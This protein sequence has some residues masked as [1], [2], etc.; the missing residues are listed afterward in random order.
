MSPSRRY[1]N[2]TVGIGRTGHMFGRPADSL[3]RALGNPW[4][5]IFATLCKITIKDDQSDPIL[6][7]YS[8][9]LPQKP[10]NPQKYNLPL[11]SLI[12]PPPTY[13]P[14]ANM[15]LPSTKAL[16]LLTLLSTF[17]IAAPIA[18]TNLVEKRALLTPAVLA[19]VSQLEAQTAGSV[20]SRLAANTASLLKILGS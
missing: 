5:L 19:A 8:S 13:H 7:H 3:C 16:A 15:L 11:Q 12:Y 9:S 14:P 1:N 17:A 4:S 18:D 6:L 10:F 2:S 20:A